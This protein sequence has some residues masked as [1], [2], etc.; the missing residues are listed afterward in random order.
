MARQLVAREGLDVVTG[1]RLFAMQDLS[2]ADAS[3]NCWN[4]KYHWD[5]WR[6]WNAIPR[7]AEDGNRA[8]EPLANWRPLISAPYPEHPSGHLCHDGASTRILRAFGDRIG[9]EITS[10]SPVLTDRRAHAQLPQL[11]PGPFGDRRGAHLGRTALPHR[12]PPG[13]GSRPEGGRLRSSP[14]LPAGRAPALSGTATLG[15]SRAA[16]RNSARNHYVRSSSGR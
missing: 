15:S 9:F 5:F 2:T 7:A 12:G 1:A 6:P 14:L 13:E 10:A 3:I 8:T 4:D 16:M 11:L